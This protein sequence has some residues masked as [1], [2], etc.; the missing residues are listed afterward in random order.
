VRLASVTAIAAGLILSN[1][2]MSA[3][4]AM[5]LRTEGNDE[6]YNL[7]LD[8]ALSRFRQAVLADPTDSASYRAVAGVSML[9][10]A[11]ER[12]A[13][14]MDEFLDGATDAT[15]VDV[16]KPTAALAEVFR[17]NAERAFQLADA[18]VRAHPDDADA[19]YQ[20]AAAVGL[21]ASYS[22]TVEGQVFAAF[23]HARRAYQESRR[24]LELDPSREDAGLILGLYQYILSLRSLPVRW[25]GK[26]GGIGNDRAKGIAL[27]EAAARYPGETQT[28]ARLAL[29]LIYN[30]ERRFDDALAMLAALQTRYPDN[31]LLAFEAGS[32]MLRANRF[33]AAERAFDRGLAT[34]AGPLTLRAFGEE[35]LWRY[36]HG[37]ALAGLNRDVEAN[38]ELQFVVQHD[39]RDWVHGRAHAELGKLAERAGDRTTAREEFRAAAQLAKTAG[40]PGGRADAE[41]LLNTPILQT[42]KTS[43]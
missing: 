25:F 26:I 10:I 6:E 11:F 18:R 29:V 38:R 15:N 22:A 28:D 7:H 23:K 19:H 43:P 39:A 17:A 21:Q 16:A 3:D 9:R 37:T 14:T 34:L 35:A 4:S 12:G 2:A 20:L 40:D 33:Q 8:Q 32:T 42:A 30:R 1:V 27:I 13:V 41:R 5:S 36:K 31:R 24:T